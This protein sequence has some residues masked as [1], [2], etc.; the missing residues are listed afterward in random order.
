MSGALRQP[1]C[2][3]G[4]APAGGHAQH[5]TCADRRDDEHLGGWKCSKNRNCLV[6]VAG[7]EPAASS[8]RSKHRTSLT[9]PLCT[10]DLTRQCVGVPWS[11]PVF[12]AVVTH[13]VTQAG[14]SDLVIW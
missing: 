6:G 9:S 4:R 7:F 3:F 2:R 10:S 11:T 8:S 13:L 12:P 5:A 14:V 1:A